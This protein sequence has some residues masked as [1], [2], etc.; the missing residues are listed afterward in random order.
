MAKNSVSIK[1]YQ[2]P[3]KGQFCSLVTAL[4]GSSRDLKDAAVQAFW[5]DSSLEY[6]DSGFKSLFR[7]NSCTESRGKS[8]ELL[9]STHHVLHLNAFPVKYSLSS[10]A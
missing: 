1:R 5:K 7:F 6:E 2:N 8:T 10:S 3:L 9:I 4:C